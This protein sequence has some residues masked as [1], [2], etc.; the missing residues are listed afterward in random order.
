MQPTIEF[1]CKIIDV[2]DGETIRKGF[3]W[4]KKVQKVDCNLRPQDHAFYNSD[5]FIGMLNRAYRKIIGGEYA[6]FCFIDNLPDNVALDA[7][8]FL[9]RVTVTLP[10]NF[11]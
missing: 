10:A 1:K 8:G 6:D 4:K 9:A 2:Q 3:S 5:M 7:S 11:R